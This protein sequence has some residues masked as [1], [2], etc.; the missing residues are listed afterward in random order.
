MAG[1]GPRCHGRGARARQAHLPVDRLFRLPLVPCAG[2]GK[3]PGRKPGRR[4]QRQLHPHPGRPRPAPRP[5][6][7]L[8][9][10]RRRHAPP[11]RLAAEHLPDARRRALLGDRLSA[12]RG[13]TG[14]CRHAHRHHRHHRLVARRQGE[15]GR[16][17]RHRA[18]RPGRP[19]QSRHGRGPGEHEPGP[20]GAAHR[21][22]LRHLLRRHAGRHQIPQRAAAAAVVERLPAHRHLA[23]LAADLHHRG[24]HAVRRSLRPC[25]RRLLPPHQ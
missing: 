25:R 1:L 24:L 23:I 22:E 4:D 21:A 5:G 12:A 7:D 15:G 20:G 10:R 8:P 18:R 9:G 11:G 16:D 14:Q 19:V 6:P 3:L 13:E 2:A 17:R